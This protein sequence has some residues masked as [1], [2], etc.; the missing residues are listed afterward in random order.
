MNPLDAHS[1]NAFTQTQTLHDVMVANGDG[2]KKVWGTEMGAATGTASGTLTE[3]QQAQWV[4]D[5]YL[6]W[7]TTF[8]SFT[9]PLVWMQLR[10]SGTNP[11]A[12]WENL[13]LQYRDRTA[14]A[15]ILRVP[16]RHAQRRELTHTTAGR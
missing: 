6:G 1:W 14:E 3:A 5:Y 11:A 13:G 10:N 8:R 16:R 2:A 4:H 12:K 9:G 15:G 7:N